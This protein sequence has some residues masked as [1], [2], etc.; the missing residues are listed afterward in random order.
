MKPRIFTQ[1]MDGPMDRPETMPLP[2][3]VVLR[4]EKTVENGPLLV[5]TGDTVQTGQRL[6]LME[7]PSVAVTATVTGTIS[8][9]E[10]VA[11][12]FGRVYWAVVIDTAAEEVFDDRFA[13]AAHTPDMATLKAFL[14]QV[15][16]LPPLSALDAPEHPVHTLVVAAADTDLFCLTRQQVAGTREK[17]IAKGIAILKAASGAKEAIIVLPQDIIQNVG[18]IGATPRAVSTEFPSALPE[19]VLRDVLGM[20]KPAEKPFEET[21]VCFVSVEAVAAI[22]CAFTQKRVPVDKV[23]TITDKAG[24]GK[25]VRV[26][27]GTP[28]QAVFDHMGIVVEEADRII[29]GGPM[30]GSAV[31]STTHPILADTDAIMIQDGGTLALPTDYPCINCGDCIRLCPANIQVNMLVRFLEAS[32]YQTAADEYDLYS[33]VE[34]GLCAFVCASKIPILQYVRLAKYELARIQQA[35]AANA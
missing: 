30:T 17:D 16:G 13:Q 12:D 28:I 3:K 34:C 22:G 6:E 10:T 18:G 11:G 8:A 20:E 31:F 23:V 14:S 24:R 5:K 9:I 15:P 1:R 19:L 4:V 35:E 27:I 25:L 32:Q 26:R 33:C 2:R 21:G 7:A 29:L